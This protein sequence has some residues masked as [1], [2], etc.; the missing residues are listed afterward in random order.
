MK[1]IYNWG[2]MGLGGIATKFAEGLCS[3]PDGCLYAVASRTQKKADEF[4]GKFNVPIAYGDYESMVKDSHVDI[5]YIAT[6]HTEHCNNTM[7]CLENKKAVLCEK[8]F[9]INSIE[10]KKMVDKAK[11]NNVFLMEAMWTACLPSIKKV[12][13]VIKSGAIGNI[14]LIRADFGILAPKDPTNR[15]FNLKL[16]GGSLLDVGIYPVFLALE[17]LGKPT[18]IKAFA[19]IGKTGVDENCG[20]VFQYE[21]GHL[22]S[23]FSSI[24]A[25]T[26][27]DAQIIGDKGK[28]HLHSLFFMPTKISL[29][30]GENSPIDITPT[31]IGN[32]YN[33]E[34][35]EAINCLKNDI[36][37][38]E[39]MSFE[40][41]RILMEVLDQIRNECG[42]FYPGHD[43]V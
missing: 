7:L 32:G 37:E 24:I 10:V 38:S 31:Y 20:I 17:L 12:K 11:E 40:K 9:A 25:R 26:G 5:I 2:I 34:A 30:K 1:K 3:V 6:P 39:L 19:S 15:L 18:N 33:Y 14:K 21:K 16:G 23:L 42:I 27:I 8:P 41:S 35:T 29:I 28:I 4:A 36:I 13:E 22:A 43:E